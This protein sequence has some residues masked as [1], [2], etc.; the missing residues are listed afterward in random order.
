MP[1]IGHPLRGIP[2]FDASLLARLRDELSV[3]TAEELVG[4]WRAVPQSV[5]SILGKRA[6]ELAD[7]AQRFLSPQDM[8]KLAQSE[9]SEYPFQTGHE[10]PPFGKSTF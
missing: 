9:Q 3:T 7:A 10:A 6:G 4:L 5:G 2:E 8:E 1:K